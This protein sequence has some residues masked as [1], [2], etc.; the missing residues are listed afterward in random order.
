MGH[1]NHC[2]ENL[3][4]WNQKNKKRIKNKINLESEIKH[5]Q[6]NY[7]QLEKLYL[8][9]TTKNKLIIYLI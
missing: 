6:E 2:N 4:S 5:P 9:K 1:K 8:I 3:T 7:N